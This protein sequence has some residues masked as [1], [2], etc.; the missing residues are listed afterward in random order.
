MLTSPGLTETHLDLNIGQ[1]M[2]LSYFLGVVSV[3]SQ[4]RT[5]DQST[6]L[7][8]YNHKYPDVVTFCSQVN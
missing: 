2:K 8:S 1:K 3:V 6:S 5:A 7:S 4:Y